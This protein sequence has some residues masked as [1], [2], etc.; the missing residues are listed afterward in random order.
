M[1]MLRYQNFT[2]G[3]AWIPEYGC[4]DN[5]EE[6][7]FLVKYSPLHNVKCPQSHD[8]HYPAML[9]M[10]AD[11]DDRVVPSHSLKFIAQL[12]YEFR[13]VDVARKPIIIRVE[14]RAGHG[15]GKPTSKIIEGKHGVLKQNADGSPE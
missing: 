9:L 7:E 8:D 5:E 6:F 10:T 11:H 13:N 1:D 3:Q 2:I 12:Y 4:S 15:F 14:V